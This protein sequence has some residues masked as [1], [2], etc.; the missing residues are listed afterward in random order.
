MDPGRH[1][2]PDGERPVR[3]AG[4]VG[5][6]D[7]VELIVPCIERLRAAG[8]DPIVVLDDHSTDGTAELVDRLARDLGSGLMRYP[9]EGDPDELFDRNGPLI[10]P[11]IE[12][13]APDWILF[14]DADEFWV[15]ADGDLGTALRSTDVD[16]LTVERYNVP[17]MEPPFAPTSGTADGPFLD[18]PIVV[19]KEQVTRSRMDEDP[20]Q[21]WVTAAIRPRV[22]CRTS[23]FGGY[24]LGAHGARGIHGAPLTAPTADR[25]VIVHVPFTTP[26]RFTRKVTNARA[27]LT[28]WA[29]QYT[30]QTAWHWRRWIEAADAGRL[31][32]EFQRELMTASMVRALIDDGTTSTARALL[33]L[34]EMPSSVGTSGRV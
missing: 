4:I 34:G 28:R 20:R 8:V 24:Q 31:D 17:L 33:G 12:R 2:N 30:G 16:A 32:A 27:F 10:G 7:E 1:M 3:I 13:H 14:T 19:R 29:A 11:L 6:K 26:E 18:A 23:R 25:I 9:R 21:R 22:L 5:V 15:A